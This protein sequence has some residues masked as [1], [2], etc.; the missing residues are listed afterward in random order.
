MQLGFC[1]VGQEESPPESW[2]RRQCFTS[3]AC[4]SIGGG[5]AIV[6]A[7]NCLSIRGMKAA[8]RNQITEPMKSSG[9]RW[10]IEDGLAVRTFRLPHGCPVKVHGG[11]W[12]CGTG[13]RKS[14][15][16]A[17]AVQRTPR[18]CNTRI[19]PQVGTRGSRVP[20]NQYLDF[21][22]SCCQQTHRAAYRVGPRSLSGNGVR[23]E[24]F[25]DGLRD[26]I[27]VAPVIRWVPRGI[28][29]SAKP[30]NGQSGP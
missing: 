26:S 24:I 14:G 11:R 29:P 20:M 4:P 25:F 5:T 23:P 27:S 1:A 22:L 2:R 19:A 7:V 6:G 3:S 21:C 12:S 13:K 8:N 18:C 9:M 30:P 16:S 17:V 15:G 10:S 28:A